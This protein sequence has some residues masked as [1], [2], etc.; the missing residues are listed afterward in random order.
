MADK[1][2]R[3]YSI[4]EGR[5]PFTFSLCVLCKMELHS[6]CV[7]EGILR[8]E[9]SSQSANLRWMKVNAGLTLLVEQ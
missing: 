8:Q 6:E 2:Q 3:L 9:C 1:W 5:Y 7:G 4:H